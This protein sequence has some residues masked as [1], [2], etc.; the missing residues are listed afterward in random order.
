MDPGGD[1]TETI[2]QPLPARRA[3]PGQGLPRIDLGEGAEC[4]LRLIGE[5]G[6]GGM[7]RVDLARQRS[8]DRDVAIKRVSAPERHARE[9]LLSEGRIQGQLDHQNIVPV[10]SLG[11]DPAGEPALVMKRLSATS[12]RALLHDPSH[13]AWPPGAGDPFVFHLQTLMQ[14]CNA[15][16]FAH[17]R[18]V[19]HRDIKP[20]N[21]MIGEL[22]QVYLIDWG[23]GYRMNGDE[24]PSPDI[25]GTPAYLAPE[26]AQGTGPHLGPHTDVYQLGAVL[27]EIL[28]GTR[29]HCG[30]DL[31]ETVLMAIESDPVDYPP[32][33]PEEL[34]S[35]CNR[36][37]SL[38]PADRPRSALEFRGAIAAFLDH[39]GSIALAVAAAARVE[40]L[41]ALLVNE[42]EK[43]SADSDRAVRVLFHEAAFGFEQALAVWPKNEVA[44]AGLD[45]ARV[46]M[47]GYELARRNHE[48]AMALLAQISGDRTD[49]L[50]RAR[51]LEEDLARERR[52][53]RAL[54]QVAWDVDPSVNIRPRLTVL[55]VVGTIIGGA[56]LAV[57]KLPEGGPDNTVIAVAAA[58]AVLIV[59]VIVRVFRDQML[60]T[61]QN[62]SLWRTI[63]ATTGAFSLNHL[64]GEIAGIA[65]ERLI[66]ADILIGVAL[67]FVVGWTFHRK[68][69]FFSPPIAITALLAARH[70]TVAFPIAAGAWVW[71]ILTVLTVGRYFILRD[72]RRRTSAQEG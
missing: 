63:L 67:F 6:R 16:H 33:V 70:P 41:R 7:G 39:R 24:L 36:A 55:A 53:I 11:L 1:S 14:V 45:D 28:T 38:D 48:A 34:A 23:L 59:L 32:S 30:L 25:V 66:P 27:H 26:M 18:G 61:R 8:L 51:A 71:A 49:L 2:R 3:S 64:T 9:A 72:A 13:P 58:V 62:E 68:L 40:R 31:I 22:G 19:L 54:R 69:A 29:R 21:V 60:S 44:R 43:P 57:W 12:W 17:T 4:D 47:F 50:A 5:I 46:W 56:I 52:E 65:P 15:V 42:T 10:Y 37:T 35:L 20:A